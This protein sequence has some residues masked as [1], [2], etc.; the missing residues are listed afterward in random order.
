MIGKS[1][2]EVSEESG[3]DQDVT[4]DSFNGSQLVVTDPTSGASYQGTGTPIVSGST[5][6]VSTTPTGS[7]SG[8]QTTQNAGTGTGVMAAGTNT[9]WAGVSWFALAS[10]S[11]NVRKAA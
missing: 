11:G 2:H 3:N 9:P 10:S 7:A 8:S 1:D 4:T 6:T 5:M